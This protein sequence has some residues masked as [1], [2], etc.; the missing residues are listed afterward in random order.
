MKRGFTLVELS[1]VL[2]IIGLLVGGILAAQS[3]ISTAKLNVI[4]ICFHMREIMMVTSQRMILQPGLTARRMRTMNWKVRHLYP[5]AAY[6]GCGFKRI[7][8]ALR[9]LCGKQPALHSG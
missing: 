2:V 8:H 4:R 1:I 7:I 5:A 9:S 6:S 3:M